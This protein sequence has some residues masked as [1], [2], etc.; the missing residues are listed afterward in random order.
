MTTQL[1][2]INIIIIIIIIIIA[3][4][5]EI[6]AEYINTLCGK[7]YVFVNVKPDRKKS[8]HRDLQG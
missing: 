6:C 1:Q 2:V 5:S 4:C 3:V 7:Q 8:N